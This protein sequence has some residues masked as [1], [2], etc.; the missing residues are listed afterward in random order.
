MFFLHK[1]HSICQVVTAA[2]PAC[3]RAP[4]LPGHT[5][6]AAAPPRAGSSGW[7][8]AD[9]ASSAPDLRP[10]PDLFTLA[11]ADLE[12]TLCFSTVHSQDS[13]LQACLHCC[14]QKP[15]DRSQSHFFNNRN[16]FSLE[17]E[18]CR[19]MRSSS[20]VRMWDTTTMT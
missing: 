15:T 12:S 18:S 5:G 20:R 7:R 16:W 10:V 19:A 9:T 13:R 17:A 4:G 1:S 8:H 2:I 14:L 11:Q 3:H 6:P